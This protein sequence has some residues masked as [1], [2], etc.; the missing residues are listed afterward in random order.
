VKANPDQPNLRQVHLIHAEL[1]EEL[2]EK[3]FA[4]GPADLGENIVTAGIALDLPRGP[5]CASGRM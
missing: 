3:G 4:V 1:F 2:R 5:S